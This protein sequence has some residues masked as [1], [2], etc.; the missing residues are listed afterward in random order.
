MSARRGHRRRPARA[1]HVR[2][3]RPDD[4]APVPRAIR[5]DETRTRPGGTSSV[6]KLL[7]RLQRRRESDLP[8]RRQ[9]GSRR[10]HGSG[11]VRRAEPFAQRRADSTHLNRDAL[12]SSPTRLAPFASMRLDSS[13][14]DSTLECR[15]SANATTTYV[16][17]SVNQYASVGGVTYGYDTTNLSCRRPLSRSS[18]H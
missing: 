18:T 9:S 13:I 14:S 1:S 6:E 10:A 7:L 11:R 12:S 4:R 15:P 8:R 17:N 5:F 16:P 3:Q 2:Q